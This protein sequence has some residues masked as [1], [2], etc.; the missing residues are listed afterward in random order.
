MKSSCIEPW[1]FSVFSGELLE[2]KLIVLLT[3]DGELF[4]PL[5]ILKVLEL[6]LVKFILSTFLD[7]NRLSWLL[8]W[9]EK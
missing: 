8:G 3:G 2:A 6:V 9:L 4:L 7:L 1:S 5:L